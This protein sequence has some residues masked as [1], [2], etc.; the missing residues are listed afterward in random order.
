VIALLA[1]LAIGIIWNTTR[2]NETPMD[3]LPRR[4]LSDI[5]EQEA[6]HANI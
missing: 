5:E 6:L 3:L 1:L 2:R 4:E